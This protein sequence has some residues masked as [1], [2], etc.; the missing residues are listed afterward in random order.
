MYPLTLVHLSVHLLQAYHVL[1]RGGIP[2]EHIIVMVYDD[3]AQ[4][5]E[6]PRLGT[7]INS[8]DGPDLYAGLPKDYTGEQV[9]AENFLAVLAGNDVSHRNNKCRYN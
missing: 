9:N 7:I 6:N 1:H 3:I 5:P 4:N 8:P 2:D